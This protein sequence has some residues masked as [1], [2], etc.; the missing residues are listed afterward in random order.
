MGT[1][2]TVERE[3]QHHPPHAH[4]RAPNREAS[5]SWSCADGGISRLGKS[6]R[7]WST[8]LHYL[9]AFP[10]CVLWVHIHH[11]SIQVYVPVWG[12]ARMIEILT[13]FSIGFQSA[14]WRILGTSLGS[15]RSEDRVSRDF[16]C[17]LAHLEMSDERVCR[18]LWMTYSRGLNLGLCGSWPP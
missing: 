7:R 1:A 5:S 16:A 18:L 4:G 12:K 13:C 15:A 17:V 8:G 9:D 14:G 10:A 2:P 3:Q 6:P 11:V